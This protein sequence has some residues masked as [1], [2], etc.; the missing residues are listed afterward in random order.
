MHTI[1]MPAVEVF[2]RAAGDRD[3][4]V[5]FN[6]CCRVDAINEP[7]LAAWQR[8]LLEVAASSVNDDGWR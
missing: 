5:A 8:T 2:I 3:S 4:V 6:T 1:H 7:A